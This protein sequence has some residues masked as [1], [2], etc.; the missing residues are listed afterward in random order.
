MPYN[1]EGDLILQDTVIEKKR[2][3]IGSQNKPIKTDIREW[4][5]FEDNNIMKGILRNLVDRKGL[6][7]SRGPGSFDKRARIIWDFVAKG[8][9]YVYDT[10]KQR[11]GDFWLFP[12]EIYT[13]HEG[14]C[15]D[16][17]FLLASLLI[18]SGI[19]PFCV[20]V[21]L[22]EVFDENGKSLGGHCW[23][24]Y[25]NEIGEWCILESTLDN[26]PSRMP[27]A[28]RLTP[29][30][31]SFQYV[32]YYCFNNYHL[33]EI[34]PKDN[35]S[36]RSMKIRSYL[37]QRGRKVHMKKTRLPSG[38]WLSR[39]TGDWE[40][41]HLEIT[42]EV[43]RSFGFPEN[44]IDILGDASQDPDFY[45]W[46]KPCAHAQTNNDEIGRTT[47]FREEA[48]RKY[49]TW[50][51]Q[52]TERIVSVT[53]TDV[54]A[55]L[56]LLGYILHSIQD[57]ATHKGITNAQHSYLSKLFGR[58]E[59]PDH[60][61]ENRT[62]AREYSKKYIE[63][64]RKKY[65]KSYKKLLAYEGRLLPWDKLMPAEKADLLNKAGWDLTPQVFTEY[66]VLSKKYEKIKKDYPVEKTIWKA[67]EIFKKLIRSI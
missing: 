13:L 1:W 65:S 45:D 37:K 36:T 58:K 51:K 41:G 35:K 27:E 49:I 29:D 23:P 10:Q 17:S 6:P 38:G 43:L 4:I 2:F 22:G 11:K 55:G 62:K 8:I 39:I 24:V 16:G 28:D 5:S 44:A 15:E 53:N 60:I 14:D 20:R 57:L 61:E 30:G 54:R 40:P 32:P 50:I 19:S 25:K 33:W 63:F 31:Q 56:F 34:F 9:K 21:V 66:S 67:D 7:T 42:G 3:V 64:L 52:L 47:E 18:A 12:P 48:E 59:D 46:Y 26:I